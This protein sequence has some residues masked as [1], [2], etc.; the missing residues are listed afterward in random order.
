MKVHAL[1]RP[2]RFG[3]IVCFGS[4]LLMA[5]GLLQMR[6]ARAETV[7]VGGTG[8]ALA[9][10]RQLGEAYRQTDPQFNLLI[11][12][13]LGSSGGMRALA[14]G[15]LDA[16]FTTREVTEAERRAG[17]AARAYGRTPVVLA[18]GRASMPG[19]TRQQVADIY[20]ARQDKWPDGTPIRLVLRPA[21]DI[22]A[23]TLAR[24]SPAI[25]AAQTEALA[26]PG[27]QVAVTDQDSAN[28]IARLPGGLGTSSLAL[29]L[30]ESRPLWMI[31]IDG[32]TPSIKTL[33]DG[34]YPYAKT[35]YIVTKGTPPEGLRKFT[36]FV[37]SARGR[38]ILEKT[39]HHTGQTAVPE[40][41]TDK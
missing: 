22:D 13:N 41:K 19:F 29:I 34:T 5:A 36:E 9:V 24:M 26:R 14:E 18:T 21:S 2:G 27:M 12:P 39:G 17:M 4:L 30:T 11:V 10:M 31:P 28:D 6:E 3:R 7:R 40:A 20:A 23:Q 33:A 38:A 32:V 35:M 37:F 16:A 8:S 25:A 1:D 15:A